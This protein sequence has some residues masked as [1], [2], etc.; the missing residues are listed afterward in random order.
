MDLASQLR[1]RAGPVSPSAAWRPP[2]SNETAAGAAPH[3]EAWEQAVRLS[4]LSSRV[5]LRQDARCLLEMID[6]RARLAND[7]VREATYCR[8]QRSAAGGVTRSYR[9]GFY[10]RR[11]SRSLS[12]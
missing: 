1:A 8:P 2:A 7:D 9:L 10:G 11:G 5:R 4:V 3:A 12:V 6:R